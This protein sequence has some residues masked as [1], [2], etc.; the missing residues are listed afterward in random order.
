MRA[1]TMTFIA[2]LTSA[3][4]LDP[5]GEWVE[6]DADGKADGVSRPAPDGEYDVKGAYHGGYS[7][8]ES[9]DGG[10][11]EVIA[12]SGVSGD[13]YY[14]WETDYPRVKVTPNADDSITVSLNGYSGVLMPGINFYE[15]I[16]TGQLGT[17]D[18][19]VRVNYLSAARW[20]TATNVVE[21]I[22]IDYRSQSTSIATSK[23]WVENPRREVTVTTKTVRWRV[24]ETGRTPGFHR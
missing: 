22:H 5:E 15:G 21:R 12:S 8:S 17:V 18:N 11:Y 10:T 24:F 4:A 19:G 9:I 13:G 20:N 3:C 14:S 16:Y 1:P 2:L 23:R 7:I 6:A